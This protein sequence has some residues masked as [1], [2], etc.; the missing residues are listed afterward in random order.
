[1]TDFV[2]IYD[3]EAKTARG[4]EM[5]FFI[6]SRLGMTRKWCQTTWHHFLSIHFAF[7]TCASVNGVVA[8][9]FVGT[10]ARP[11]AA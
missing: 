2:C 4:A 6:K 1:M 7:G 3:S 5:V 9:E 10:S 11:N 8:S